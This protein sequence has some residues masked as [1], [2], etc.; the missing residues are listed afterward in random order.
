DGDLYC[1][2]VGV[3]YLRLHNYQTMSYRETTDSPV[4]SIT[5][6]DLELLSVVVSEGIFYVLRRDKE[7]FRVDFFDPETLFVRTAKEA[8]DAPAAPVDPP[9]SFATG[10]QN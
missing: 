8:F 10:N 7:I 6:E 4:D 5:E 9:G 2:E 1:L 3:G